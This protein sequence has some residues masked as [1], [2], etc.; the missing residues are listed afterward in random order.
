M[1]S[2]CPI[3][4]A[5]DYL[6]SIARFCMHD[7]NILCCGWAIQWAHWALSWSISCRNSTSA[8]QPLQ[9]LIWWSNTMLPFVGCMTTMLFHLIDIYSPVRVHMCKK[10]CTSFCAI[11][12]EPYYMWLY[13]QLD[14]LSC[15]V[16]LFCSWHT[17][18]TTLNWLVDICDVIKTFVIIGNMTWGTQIADPCVLH[19]WEKCF[20]NNCT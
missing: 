14:R 19:E 13:H 17:A 3:S 11:L 5:G 12:H 7:I 15:V 16:C 8:T 4:Y 20:P 18:R 9:V 6:N 1:K 2:H 10:G